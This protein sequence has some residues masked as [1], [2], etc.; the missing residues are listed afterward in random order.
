[1]LMKYDIILV[2]PYL[3][4]RSLEEFDASFNELKFLP[5]NFGHGLVHLKRLSI[6]LNKIACLPASIREMVSLTYMDVHFNE[7]HGLPYS[8][9]ELK[10]LEVLNLSSN[11]NHLTTIPDTIGELSNLRELDISNNQIRVLPSTISQLVN[12][13]KLNLDQNPL[14]TP[15]AHISAKGIEAVM[16]FMKSRYVNNSAAAKRVCAAKNDERGPSEW[17]Q[18]LLR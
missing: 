18:A 5:N 14:V 13:T 7:L 8:I 1:M 6:N 2:N 15:P 9:G 12:I 3:R 4:C 11:F 16:N 10:N 17:H